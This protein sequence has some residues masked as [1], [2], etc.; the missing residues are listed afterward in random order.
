MEEASLG[1]EIERRRFCIEQATMLN[2]ADSDNM[3]EI[4]E[5]IYEYIYG[6]RQWTQKKPLR[7]SQTSLR[8]KT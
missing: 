2:E 6:E 5:K 1:Q 7:K 8:P 3:V 4:A